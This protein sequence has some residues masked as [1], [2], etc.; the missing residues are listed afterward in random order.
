MS[1]ARPPPR[2]TVPADRAHDRVGDDV[3]R[4]GE[5]VEEIAALEVRPER[6][7]DVAVG[8]RVGRRQRR[9]T[10]AACASS[11]R[12][13]IA[14]RARS[15]R[16]ASTCSRAAVDAPAAGAGPECR[17]RP[18]RCS[19]GSRGCRRESRRRRGGGTARSTSSAARRS[20]GT[21]GCRAWT[22]ISNH[23]RHPVRRAARAVGSPAAVERRARRNCSTP[24]Q[25]PRLGV[26]DPRE[27]VVRRPSAC[28]GSGARRACA[29]PSRGRRRRTSAARRRCPNASGTMLQKPESG[30]APASGGA[31][32]ST[33]CAHDALRHRDVV[34][35]R[36]VGAERPHRGL[37][38]ARG[39]RCD[40]DASTARPRR[41]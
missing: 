40:R 20:R 17:R 23:D 18:E 30:G 3:G 2:S 38:S 22:C 12:P 1:I 13:N 19:S 25:S 7:D 24:S 4:V 28:G 35:R 41:T 27:R 33:T 5:A 21:G 16:P 6:L 26:V 14:R 11:S 32:L 9:R 36:G 10:R 31:P 34:E 8:R 15:G 37:R 39:R 29:A